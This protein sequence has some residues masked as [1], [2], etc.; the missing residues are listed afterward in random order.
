M[1]DFFSV[2][3]G[4]IF[5]SF[6]NV[7]VFRLPQKQSVVF[8]PSYCPQCQK[9]ILWKDKIPVLSYLFLGGKCRFCRN[10]IVS[11][12]FWIEILGGLFFWLAFLHTGWNALLWFRIWPMLVLFLAITF[13]DLEHRI[14]P[15]ELNW[16][17]WI[18]GMGT[19]WM[20]PGGWLPCFLGS[21]LGFCV[22]YALAWV[23]FV[24][25]NQSGLGGGD[26][27]LLAMIGTFLGPEGVFVTIVLSSLLGSVVGMGYA[28]VRKEQ[29][30]TQTALPFGP[31][32]IVGALSYYFFGES[33]WLKWM[34]PN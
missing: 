15:D 22:F 13:I 14:I 3:L 29:H 24:V 9:S 18:L 17:G 34:M 7:L 27:K 21:V 1:L 26:I 28:L 11:R 16:V 32:L 2:V 23:Y 30:W 31:F 33:L 5:G 19:S 4:L 8:R 6:T 20:I 12:Y 25:R 10:P